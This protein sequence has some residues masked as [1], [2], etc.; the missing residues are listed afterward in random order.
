MESSNVMVYGDESAR[1]APASSHECAA[2]GKRF[3][4]KGNLERHLESA[5]VCRMWLSSFPEP[6]AISGSDG[7]ADATNVIREDLPPPVRVRAV[8]VMTGSMIADLLAVTG[9]T[10]E[11]CGKE[12][13][14]PGSLTR[15]F[16]TSVACDRTRARALMAALKVAA[17]DFDVL[18]GTTPFNELQDPM[19]DD[20]AAAFGCATETAS[21]II[22]G[23]ALLQLPAPVKVRG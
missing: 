23:P 8:P 6:A 22:P 20:R 21:Q 10:C 15:H 12:F 9:T 18:A 1:L 17:S 16:R 19:A 3:T 7:P 11:F 13:S 4:T 14:T 5:K 2:C